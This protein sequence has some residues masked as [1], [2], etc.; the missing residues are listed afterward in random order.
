MTKHDNRSVFQAVK[1]ITKEE[2]E[3]AIQAT[4]QETNIYGW[5][6]DTPPPGYYRQGG[7]LIEIREPD[8]DG[9]IGV[10]VQG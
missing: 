4:E 3:A 2:F 5:H 8:E 6:G 7:T 10:A 9:C 1:P